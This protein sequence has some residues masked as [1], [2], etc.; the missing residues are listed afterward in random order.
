MKNRNTTPTIQ[1][2][3]ALM[4]EIESV[5][6]H[7]GVPAES[8]IHSALR[9]IVSDCKNDRSLLQSFVDEIRPLN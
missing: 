3:P 7:V 1:V 9:D 6:S 4:R 5:C 8:F 2:E